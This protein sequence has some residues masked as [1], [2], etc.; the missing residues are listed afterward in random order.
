M[1]Q[2]N[3]PGRSRTAG[4]SCP[5]PITMMK[6]ADGP[7]AEEDIRRRGDRMGHE[8]VKFEEDDGATRFVIRKMK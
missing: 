3:E 8:I 7:A 1:E 2:E 4:L 5:M 6:G